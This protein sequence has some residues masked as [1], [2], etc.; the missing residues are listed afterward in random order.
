MEEHLTMPVSAAH[1]L[2]AITVHVKVFYPPHTSFRLWL[3]LKL[4]LVAAWVLPCKMEVM[5]H[6]TRRRRQ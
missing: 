3:G 4:M 6:A 1:A 5:K 2:K